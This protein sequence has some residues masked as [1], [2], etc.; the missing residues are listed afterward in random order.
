MKPHDVFSRL[1]TSMKEHL[2]VKF[3][4]LCLFLGSGKKLPKIDHVAGRLSRKIEEILTRLKRSILTSV[5]KTT[6]EIIKCTSTQVIVVL[7]LKPSTELILCLLLHKL[8]LIQQPLCDPF[9]H[10]LHLLFLALPRYLMY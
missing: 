3:T 7:Y 1:V 6:L 8:R 4:Q 10:R 2:I 9:K 5:S